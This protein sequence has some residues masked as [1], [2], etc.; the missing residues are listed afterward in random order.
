[1][2]RLTVQNIKDIISL[3]VNNI[4]S[5]H[6]EPNYCTYKKMSSKDKVLFITGPVALTIA[7]NKSNHKDSVYINNDINND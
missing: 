5:T 7:I 4:I 6:Y 2:K 1:M 3:V